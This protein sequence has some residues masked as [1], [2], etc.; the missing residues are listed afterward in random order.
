[1]K[2]HIHKNIHTYTYTSVHPYIHVYI[3]RTCIIH[4][5]TFF[6]VKFDTGTNFPAVS[7]NS[8]LAVAMMYIRHR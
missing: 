2:T 6:V 7:L 3:I 5:H 4:I 1:M 8:L